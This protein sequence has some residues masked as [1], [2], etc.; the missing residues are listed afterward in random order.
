MVSAGPSTA[1]VAGDIDV[2]VGAMRLAVGLVIVNCT[3]DET[4]NELETVTPA[5]PAKAVSVGKIEAVS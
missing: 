3:D 4:P 2:R 1:A 5:V